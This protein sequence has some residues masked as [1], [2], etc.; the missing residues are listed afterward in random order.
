MND[1]MQRWSVIVMVGALMA[2]CASTDKK[3]AQGELPQLPDWVTKPVIE[4]GIAVTEC[5]RS[6]GDMS[7][8]KAEAVAN[9]RAAM[10]KQISVKVEAMDKTYQRKVKTEKG[11]SVGG[12]FESVS[13]QVTQQYLQG[14]RP[15]KMDFVNIGNQRN[16]CTMVTLAPEATQD[17]FD[18]IVKQSDR[19]L[20]PRDKRVLYEEFKAEKAQEELEK[21]LRERGLSGR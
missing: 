17:L 9:A 12:S 14:S 13:K 16:L 1:K 3:A 19:K 21:E 2:G 20:S 11:D 18:A 10:A 7:L 5:V 8:D 4:D 15:T 6:S